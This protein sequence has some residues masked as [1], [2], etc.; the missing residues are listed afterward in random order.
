MAHPKLQGMAEIDNLLVEPGG[1]PGFPGPTIIGR[2]GHREHVAQE[3][4]RI[5]LPVLVDERE[6]DFGVHLLSSSWYFP[7]NASFIS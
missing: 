4:Y 6:E 2:P 3:R 5:R 7:R 1:L